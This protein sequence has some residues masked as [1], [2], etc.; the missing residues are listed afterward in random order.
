M[1]KQTRIQQTYL[2]RVGVYKKLIHLEPSMFAMEING[3]YYYYC[4]SIYF[5]KE[6]AKQDLQV[7]RNSGYCDAFIVEN[8]LPA[9][10]FN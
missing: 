3:Y 5:T 1:D 6:L 7:I 2:I 8:P 10:Y 9:I 4:R